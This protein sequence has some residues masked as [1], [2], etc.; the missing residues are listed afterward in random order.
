MI[1]T[2]LTCSGCSVIALSY[3]RNDPCQSDPKLGR[4]VNYQIPDWCGASNNR[5][6]IYNRQNQQIGHIRK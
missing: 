5:V 2:L 1:T 3:N 4:A 6:G